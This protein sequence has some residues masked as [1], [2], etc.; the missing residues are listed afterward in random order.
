MK[1]KLQYLLHMHI[2]HFFL[3]VLFQQN[4]QDFDFGL[5]VV[6]F[7]VMDVKKKLV[8]YMIKSS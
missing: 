6:Y 2:F 5:Q 1:K 4:V 7:K 3:C 8:I